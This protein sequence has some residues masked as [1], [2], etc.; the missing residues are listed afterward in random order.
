V[1]ILYITLENLSLHKGSVVHIREVIDGLQKKGHQV[2]L[3]GRAY[4]QL[5]IVEHFFNIH[6][7]SCFLLKFLNIKKKYYILSS[8]LLFFNLL[9]FLPRYDIIYARDYHTVIIAFLPRLIFKK[10]LLFEING[11]ANEEQRLK[12]DSI[13]NRILAFFIQKVEK[14]AAQY[15]NRI[16]AVTPQIASYLVQQFVC[17]SGKIEVVSNGVNTKIFHPI[18]DETLLSNL[19]K[20]LGIK[21]RETVLIFV[22]NLAPWQGLDHLIQIAPLLIR[23]FKNIKFLIIGDGILKK[24]FIGEVERLRL[25]NHFIFTGMVDYQHIPIYI[26][27]ADVCLVMKRRLASGYSPIKLYEYMACG[28]P[29][30][31]SRVEGLEFIEAE[32]AGLVTESKDLISLEETLC[33]LL[34]DTQKKIDMGQKGL[35]IARERFNWDSKVVNIE[36][37]LKE[38]V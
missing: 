16:I 35:R 34:Q 3:M 1:K 14:T 10:K 11:L 8:I 18:H 6:P 15:S 19:R 25:S 29:I 9:K 36:K 28:K 33:G 22:G 12:G 13:L 24:E 17:K 31:A 4:N 20:K 32:G 7:A 38:L 2:G 23:K 27:I 5:N 30:V 37:I 26:N 21:E